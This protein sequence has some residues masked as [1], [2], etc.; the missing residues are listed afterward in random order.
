MSLFEFIMV[1]VSIIIGM[2]VTELLAGLADTI[3]RKNSRSS[4]ILLPGLLFPHR[5]ENMGVNWLSCNYRKFFQIA[6]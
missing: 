4:C 2:S 6:D 3:T 5:A 1:L